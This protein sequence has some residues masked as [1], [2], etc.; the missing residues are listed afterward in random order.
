M[1]PDRAAANSDGRR[2]REPESVDVDDPR[3]VTAAQDYLAAIEA[4][5]PLDRKAFIARHSDIAG[6]LT[7]CLEGLEFVHA[8]AVD[9]R[10]AE[11][12]QDVAKRVVAAHAK[13]TP[14]AAAPGATPDGPLPLGDFRLLR[15]IGRGGMGVV[16]EAIQLSLDRRVAVKILPFAA[17][18]DPKHLQ[19]FKNESQAA[20]QLHHTNIVPVY[21]VGMQRGVHFYAMQLIDGEPL[22]A[23][24]AQ[25]R[26]MAGKESSDRSG[27]SVASTL[28]VDLVAGGLAPQRRRTRPDD[29]TAPFRPDSVQAMTPTVTTSGTSTVLAASH[30]TR[31]AYFRT[32]ALLMRQTAVALEHAHQEGVVHRDIKPANLILDHRGNIWVTDFGLAQFH[33]DAN[34]TRTGDMMGTLRYMSPEQAAG[35]R[36]VLDH[37][38]DIYSLGVT[39]YELL[40][41]EPLFDGNDRQALVRQIIDDEPRAP[42]LLDKSIPIELETIVL[43]AIAKS[44]AERYATAQ[45]LADD[46]QRFLDDKPILARRPTLLEHAARWRRRHR[47]VVVSAVV[48]LFLASLGLLGSTIVIA[49]EHSKTKI[50]YQHEAQQRE[51]AE[52]SFRQARQAVDG[53]TQLA[54]Q[55][56]AGQ[57]MLQP[58]RRKFLELTLG[59]YR[60]FIDQRAG[61][62]DPTIRAELAATSERVA[63]IVDELAALQRLAPLM[64]LT[65]ARVQKDLALSPAAGEQIDTLLIGLAADTDPDPSSGETLNAEEKRHQI[66]AVLQSTEQ[67]IK[68]VLT[69]EQLQR[70]EQI[71]WQ[72]RGPF[73]FLS[74]EATAALSL[75]ADQREKIQQAI[76][77]NRPG[78]RGPHGPG[79]GGPGEHE[80]GDRGPGEREFGGGG[81]AQREFGEQ[82]FGE[83][84][85]E[86]RGHGPPGPPPDGFRHGLWRATARWPLV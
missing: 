71:A 86:D 79:P 20:A 50:A 3:I 68:R 44:P 52:E 10:K 60:N 57:P 70:L 4:G 1:S 56:L 78:P 26:R 59:Y 64:L 7:A 36:V 63:R 84:G 45:D 41:L 46:L 29:R 53:F 34:L 19:R 40:T 6:E 14:A 74:S 23:L 58:L 25:M 24:I 39:L 13:V 22:S 76:E 66:A 42:R 85:F 49:H 16:Y 2:Q 37:R 73:A 81:F 30:G 33:A 43:K 31:P 77:H 62:T 11:A 35:N 80:P 21:A 55:E 47:S 51:A 32:V 17:S 82:R 18:L 75:T 12:N 9:M 15:E 83:R 38:T 5:R 27:T 65:D 48:L 54:E 8:L 61:D 28:A 67:E 72:Q 69:A